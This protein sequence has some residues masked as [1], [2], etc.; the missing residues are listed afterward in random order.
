MPGLA[1]LNI[2]DS[3]ESGVTNPCPLLPYSPPWSSSGSSQTLSKLG[4]ASK[5]LPFW[6]AAMIPFILLEHHGVLTSCNV[7]PQTQKKL[8]LI[9]W[10]CVL[11]HCQLQCC[12]R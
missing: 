3:P 12:F 10:H 5:L 11:L 6:C 2:K 8:E 4:S 1:L 7:H 9:K